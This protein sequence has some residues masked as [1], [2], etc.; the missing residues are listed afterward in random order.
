MELKFRDV[1]TLAIG[2]LYMDLK[3]NR[4]VDEHL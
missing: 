3:L 1:F 4:L 2:E